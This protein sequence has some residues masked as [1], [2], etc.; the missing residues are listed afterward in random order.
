MEST[1]SGA[2]QQ[3]ALIDPRQLETFIVIGV[4]DFLD[5]LGDVIRDVPVHLEYIKSAIEMGNRGE[6]NNRAHSLRGMLAYFGC[7]AMTARLN[8]LEHQTICPPDQ[9]VTTHTELLTLWQQSLNA[10]KEWEKSVPEFAS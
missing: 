3:L 10:I 4:V 6:L 7:L 2:T 9:A 8:Q 5:L 1:N